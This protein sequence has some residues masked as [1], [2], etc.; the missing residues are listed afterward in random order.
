M[1]QKKF[2]GIDIAKD[3]FDA[4][5]WSNKGYQ[6]REFSNTEKGFKT[7]LS[8]V[9]KDVKDAWFCMEATGN[10][11]IPLADY[12]HGEGQR[13]SVINPLQIKRF[14]QSK[15][16]RNKTDPLDAKTIAEY[17]ALTEPREY[18]PKRETQREIT[19]LMN[20]LNSL[21]RELVSLK[22]Q[23]SV[24]QGYV[25][26]R[27]LA[28]TIKRLE[29][30]I[31]LIEKELE[32]LTKKDSILAEQK[33]L[34]TSISGIGDVTSYTLLGRVRDIKQFESAK[35][36]AAFIG[37]TPCRR[38]SGKYEGKTMMSRVG[39]GQLRRV[40]YMAALVGLRYNPI[41][42]KFAER[43]RA[44]G[45]A[46]KSIIGA[47]MRKLAH[48]IYGVLKSGKAFDPNYAIV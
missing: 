7:F 36:F 29:K 32:A 11:G 26:K 8:W 25:S 4:A 5:K 27:L 34:L 3:K 48:I 9:L 38:Q 2:V 19:E 21:K 22:N 31:A 20:L 15:L 16:L 33:E 46:P 12:L 30:E 40:L 37:V 10:Y 14:S 13:V 39:D 6:T 24:A 1:N 28:N 42:K 44:K 35:Q 45:K 17:G 41:L 43:L 23:H 47:A 18:E